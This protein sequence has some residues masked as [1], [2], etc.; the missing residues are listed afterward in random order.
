MSKKSLAD[1][2]VVWDKLAT[3]IK[4]KAS[5]LPALQPFVEVLKDATVEVREAKQRQVTL[6]AAAQQASRD[7][8]AAMEKASEA[9]VRLNRGILSAYGY[10]S[11]KLVEFGLRPW[12]PRRPKAAP[13]A[14]EAPE[15]DTQP[16]PDAPKPRR[17]RRS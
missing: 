13:E 17:K 12:R 3:A 9:E 10:K 6:R 7:L 11:E 8:E 2:L 16:L 15:S 5:E 1:H 4:N 14:P